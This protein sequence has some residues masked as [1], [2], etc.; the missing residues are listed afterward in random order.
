MTCHATQRLVISRHAFTLFARWLLL[1]LALAACGGG[2]SDTPSTPTTPIIPV[3]PPSELTQ[4]YRSS[5]R[6]IAGDVFVH[7][8][9]WR[10]P[11]IARECELFLGPKG[12]RGVQISPPS[13]HAIITTGGAFYP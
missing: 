1:C 9:E 5:G 12:Y 11:D 6:A 13:E 4:D 7:L 2:K 8:F 3:P 10:W